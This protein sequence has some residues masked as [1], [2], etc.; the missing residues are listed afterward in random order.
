MLGWTIPASASAMVTLVEQARAELEADAA[1]SSQAAEQRFGLRR[2]LAD[3]EGEFTRL[4][5]EIGAM[6]RQPSNI[7]NA[8]LRLRDALCEAVAVPVAK[9]PFAGELMQV[10]AA[11]STWQGAAERVLRGLALSLVVEERFYDKVSRWVNATHLG[12]RLVFLRALPQRGGG[13]APGPNSL[14]RKI[15]VA[16]GELAEWMS[17]E[18]RARFDYECIADLS[19]FRAAQRAAVTP[20]GLVKHNHTRHEMTTAA[21]STTAAIGCS[22]STTTPSCSSS[23]P[24]RKGLATRSPAC[25]GDSACSM[26]AMP[27]TRRECGIAR[28]C[29]TRSGPTSTSARCCA[30]W[31]S[32][33]GASRPSRRRART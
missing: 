22:G 30:R 19:L 28:P 15:D 1:Q 24:M 6:E 11:E 14:V 12:L 27:G 3:R 8:M 31:K 26:T 18:L 2:E 23:A 33:A 25:S 10:K 17:E 21:R 16:P 29:V 32:S 5:D 20:Q 4:R 13:A 9:L 7:P